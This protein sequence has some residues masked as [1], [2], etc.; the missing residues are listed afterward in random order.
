MYMLC[1]TFDVNFNYM[2]KTSQNFKCIWMFHKKSMQKNI[3]L[4]CSNELQGSRYMLCIGLH[5][6]N[7]WMYVFFQFQSFAVTLLYLRCTFYIILHNYV[8][9]SLVIHSIFVKLSDLHRL[10]LLSKVIPL[11]LYGC[12]FVCRSAVDIRHYVPVVF[13]E[14]LFL[15][16]AS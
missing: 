6:V 15:P 10:Q 4:Q 3:W 16:T 13:Y 8:Y 9:I 5:Y 11:D 7:G 12:S 14:S 1:R 2:S